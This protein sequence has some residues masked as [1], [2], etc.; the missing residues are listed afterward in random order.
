MNA[1][2]IVAALSFVTTFGTVALYYPKMKNNRA[3]LRPRF[4]QTLMGLALV[5]AFAG[6]LLHPGIA[7]YILGGLSVVPAALFLLA[8]STSGLPDQKLAAS[9]GSKTPDFAAVDADGQE[10][11]LSEHA[12]S[13]ILLKFYR[14]YWCPYCVAELTQL[15]RV[16]DDFAALGVKLVAIS[17]DRVDELQVFKQK[18]N[19][20]ITLLAD[21]SL[22]V[23]RLFN[24]QHR[25]FT[26]KHGP[27]RELAIP[28]TILID[29]D[30]RI[31]WLEQATDF[32]VRPQ[33]DVVLAKTRSLLAGV[34]LGAEDGEHCDVC[35]A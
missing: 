15:N 17:S 25:N 8:T 31:A 9:V 23:H 26:P 11:R 4:E 2:I 27:F 32:R 1:G 16:A 13:A 5:L 24:V 21:P 14:G 19:W 20:A 6:F 29:A 12:G 35:A 28:T 34:G 3:A 7:G 22:A 30:G 10:F 33:A 18:H